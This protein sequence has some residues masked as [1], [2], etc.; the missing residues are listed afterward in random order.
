MTNPLVGDAS[1][2]GIGNGEVVTPSL[3]RNGTRSL[4]CSA[5]K[6]T[7]KMMR[8]VPRGVLL[9]GMGALL[10][11]PASDWTHRETEDL[12]SFSENVLTL[13]YFLTTAFSSISSLLGELI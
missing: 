5:R 11:A 7:S 13:Q 10:K 1:V 6:G 9:R 2:Y 4:T 12:L 8:G 3:P